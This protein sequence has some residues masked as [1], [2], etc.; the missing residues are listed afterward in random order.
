MGFT[1][2]AGRWDVCYKAARN[3]FKSYGS[4]SKFRGGLHHQ[5]ITIPI[6]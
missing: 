6:T 5:I 2:A 1:V 3:A 4:Q